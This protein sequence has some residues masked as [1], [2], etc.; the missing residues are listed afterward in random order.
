MARSTAGDGGQSKAELLQ[1]PDRTAC[2]A[3]G[4]WYYDDPATPTSVELCPATCT[5]VE[6]DPTAG[7]QILVGCKTEKRVVR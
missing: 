6:H 7:V 5:S 4:G 2:D 1:V 3:T